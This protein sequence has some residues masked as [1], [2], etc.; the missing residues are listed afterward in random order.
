MRRTQLPKGSSL[1]D[2]LTKNYTVTASGCWEY[3][4]GSVGSGYRTIYHD[5]KCHYAHRL[6]YEF[7]KGKIP[8]G[9]VVDH[10]CHNRACMNPE[11]LRVC[12]QKENVGGVQQP[13]EI[14]PKC[15]TKR[16]AYTRKNGTVQRQCP[17][18]ARERQRAWYAKNK[19]KQDRVG[20]VEKP[21]CEK[22]QCAKQRVSW[23]AGQC[24]WYCP[25]CNHDRYLKRRMRIKGF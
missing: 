25:Q 15:G 16:V 10:L 18:C 17:C 9:L 19:K 12:T 1:E 11:H 2:K 22:H 24:K 6:S 7:Y 8:A 3:N 4:G 13:I 5:G 21:F 20:G 14:C 23:K